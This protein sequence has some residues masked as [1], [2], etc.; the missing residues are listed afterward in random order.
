RHI[1][2]R[3]EGRTIIYWCLRFDMIYHS[4]ASGCLRF[5][6]I[7]HQRASGCLRFDMIYH[8]RSF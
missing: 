4:E 2:I 7:Y 5:D 1:L 8:Q 3:T 6:M